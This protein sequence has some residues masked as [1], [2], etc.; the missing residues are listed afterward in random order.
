MKFELPCA[1]MIGALAVSSLLAAEVKAPEKTVKPAKTADPLFPDKVVAKGKGFEVKRSE[2]EDA[3]LA[4]KSNL[5]AAGQPVPDDER[6]SVESKLAERLAVTKILLQKASETDREK[7]KEVS[8][9]I[10][11]DTRSRFPSEDIFVQQLKS[12]GLSI[13]EFRNRLLEQNTCEEVLNRE[14]RSKIKISDEQLKSFYEENPAQ[15]EQPETVRA[16]HILFSTQDK[17]TQ[18]PLSPEQKKARETKIKKL[19]SR[20]EAGEDFGKLAREYSEDP[21]SKDKGGEYT[22]SRGQM[23]KP[24]ET[25]AFSLKTNQISDVI[26][27]DFGYHIIKLHERIPAKKVELA[28]ARTNLTS[29]LVQKE[30]EKRLPAYFEQLKKEY[31]VEMLDAEAPAEKVAEIEPKKPSAK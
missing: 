18:K 6:A 16:S 2:V 29:F 22:F 1:A 26:E 12:R 14:L 28:T 15:F 13:E 19:K 3:Y 4:F 17:I 31:N 30:V 25:A 20:A 9:K 24:F 7:A 27:T 23:V 11:A 5:V 21:G 10:V 8:D